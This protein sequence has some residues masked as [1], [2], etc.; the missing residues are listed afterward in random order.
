M[1]ESKNSTSALKIQVILGVVM[2]IVF[3]IQGIA[4]AAAYGFLIGLVNLFLLNLTF[5]KANEKSAEDPKMGVLVLYMSAVFRFI[6][7][8]VLFVLGLS[9]LKLNPLA[10]VITFVVMQ[11]GQVFNLKGKQRLT[12]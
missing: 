6:L 8:A 5:K 9:L 2:I 7:M 4:W 11:L 3:A 1:M 10:V 12:D